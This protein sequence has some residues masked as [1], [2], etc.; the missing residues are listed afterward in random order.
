MRAR[1]A[2]AALLATALAAVPATAQSRLADEYVDGWKRVC[3]YEL[4]TIAAGRSPG[5]GRPSLQ[6]GRG[7]PCPARY[8]PP[9][10]P[11]SRSAPPR[12]PGMR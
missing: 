9:R 1:L 11:P 5:A 2:A 10:R 6:V 8:T 7:E 12:R 3:V 4:L